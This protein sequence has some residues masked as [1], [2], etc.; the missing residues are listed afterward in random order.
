MKRTT[1]F[2]LMVVLGLSFTAAM[3]ADAGWF[4]KDKNDKE[5]KY[6]P[7]YD[8]YPTM[9]FHKGVLKRGAGNGWRLNDIDVQFMGDCKIITDGSDEGYLQEGRIALITGPRWGN[10][11]VAWRVR[12]M[13]MDDPFND[14]NSQTALEPGASP[15]VAVG[16]GPE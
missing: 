12:V 1:I 16:H 11:V 3:D 9:G 5:T 10:T 6:V 13:S 8:E 15:G 7:R 2:I 4:S 14:Y